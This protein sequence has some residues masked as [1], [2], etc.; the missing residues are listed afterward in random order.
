MTETK[1][2]RRGSAPK[3]TVKDIARTAGVSPQ[4][5]I[6]QSLAAFDVG[7]VPH[8][9]GSTGFAAVDANGGAAS[10]AVTLNCPFGDTRLLATPGFS[11]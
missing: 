8:D 10:C 4:I 2:P 11:G 6:S 9:L 7:A 1:P 3:A 5:A